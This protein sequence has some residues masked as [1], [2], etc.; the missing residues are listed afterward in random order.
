MSMNESAIEHRYYCHLYDQ[1]RRQGGLN[2]HMPS[3][4]FE[5]NC[6]IKS[7]TTPVPLA[8]HSRELFCISPFVELSGVVYRRTGQASSE[9]VAGI[10]KMCGRLFPEAPSVKVV[11]PPLR[12]S[13][14]MYK[15]SVLTVRSTNAVQY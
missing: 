4:D 3:F 13:P 5:R 7:P 10:N 9:R 12:S 15:Q 1:N 2:V 14:R 6:I 8:C 11:V